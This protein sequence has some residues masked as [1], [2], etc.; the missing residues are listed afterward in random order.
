MPLFSVITVT[1]GDPEGLART[2]ASVGA[3]SCADFEW[4]VIDGDVE[5]DAGIYDAMNKGLARACGT[6]AVFMNGGDTFYAADTLARVASFLKSAPDFAYGDACEDGRI[7]PARHNIARGMITHHQAMFYRRG[8]LRYDTRYR[9]AADY[10]YTAETIRAAQSVLYLPF[11][12]CVFATG[13]ISQRRADDGR[14]EQAAIRKEL[15][16]R[17]PFAPLLQA[18]AQILRHA[19]PA[20]YWACRSRF[21]TSRA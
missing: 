14:R 13:G 19:A 1:K 9:I 21:K 17:A 7:K 6:Y 16:I 5:P 3:Q 18:T 20:L 15:G 10:K 4:V 12:V 2:R 8:N 11:P